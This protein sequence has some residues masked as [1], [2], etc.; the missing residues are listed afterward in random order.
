MHPARVVVASVWLAVAFAGACS[1]GDGT[2]D[3][4]PDMPDCAV[5][6]TGEII[7]WDS[8]N[9]S[10]CGVFNSTLTVRGQQAPADM[11]N[12]NGRYEACVP[13]QAQTLV[14]VMHSSSA[15]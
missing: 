12:P 6:F 10:F 3:A 13:R 7:D 8:S 9:A 14:D 15:S 11:S 1:D 5:M 4:S 2:K